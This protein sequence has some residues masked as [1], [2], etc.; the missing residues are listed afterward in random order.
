MAKGAITVK[1][2]GKYDDRDLN[3]AIKD[4]NAL[5][6]QSGAVAGPMASLGKAALAAGAGFAS[7]AIL[8]KV[9]DFMGDAMQAAMDEE[10]SVRALA[11]A[12]DN[13]GLSAKL[14]DAELGVAR[15]SKMA[16]VADDDLRPALQTLVTATGDVTKSQALLETALNVS[17]ATGKDLQTVTLAIA[18][19]STGQIG[20]LKKLGIPLDENIVKTKDFA[21]AIDVM[22]DRFGGQAAAAAKTYAGRMKSVTIAVD[23]A[24]E[25][26]GFS[27]LRALDNTSA[28]FGGEGGMND[29]IAAAG[30]AAA[31][32]IT[33]IGGMVTGLADLAAAAAHAKSEDEGTNGL[34]QGLIDLANAGANAAGI[35]G[36]PVKILL[37]LAAA[38]TQTNEAVKATSAATAASTARWNALTVAL[39]PTKAALLGVAGATEDVAE[40]MEKAKTASDR[41]KA[42]LDKYTT[43]DSFILAMRE[44]A[45]AAREAKGDINSNKTAAINLRTEFGTAAGAVLDFAIANGTSAANVLE[46]WDAG[47]KKL[48]RKLIENNVKPADVDA[49]I[50]ERLWMTRF[51]LLAD[52]IGTGR[53][54]EAMRLAGLA[55]GKAAWKGMV[56]G[57]DSG[58]DEV[59]LSAGQ[60]AAAARYA[61]MA[62]LEVNS[63]SKKFI[64][65]GKSVGEGFSLGIDAG[66]SAVTDSAKAIVKSAL[67]AARDQIA[68]AKAAMQGVSDSIVGQVLG[69]VGFSTTDAEGNALTPE[70]IV[71]SILGS[72]ANQQA[73]V[74]AIAG[75]IGTALPPALLQQM[76]A[77]PPETAIALAKYLGGAEGSP[78]LTE[79][80]ANYAK[81]A[82]ATTTLLGKPMGDA[83]GMVGD[84]SAKQMLADARATIRDLAPGFSDFV[85]R[86]LSTTIDVG[87]NFTG[88]N[89]PGRASGGPVSAGGTY[90]VGERGP[91]LLTMG[92]SSGNIT[93]NSS[94]GGGSARNTY[95]ITVQS[96][97]GD[98]R[99]IGQQVVE[100]VRKFEQA[101]GRVWA[102]A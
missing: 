91:E 75:N 81:L 4:L 96:G 42:S 60:L 59:A 86:Q 8:G 25:A 49:F 30:D 97:V 5:K 61:A 31:G 46:L 77:L 43:G 72:T 88:N 9:A 12:F 19:A 78:L 100:Y 95:H 39:D 45:K 11:V 80:T 92:S 40:D 17:A 69:N 70:Q 54:A 7:F 99:V 16:A 93:P 73:A 47:L 20:A 58:R 48:R 66:T 26:I 62:D 98:P 32:L 55:A 18:K 90:L 82:T 21:G 10:K 14:P 83:W 87:V 71:A 22:N 33:G 27:L 74:T 85:R 23:E 52:S 35:M 56:A 1:I 84:K 63:P 101:N 68:Q 37:A 29:S 3:R 102:A 28:A 51:Q 13:L 65:I 34:V 89:I 50:N 36:A 76:L 64:A 41:L 67:S 24:K 6:S 38:G 57:L 15:L 79:L 44:M 53:A 94:L 2:D